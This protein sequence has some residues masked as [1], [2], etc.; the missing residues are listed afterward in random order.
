MAYAPVACRAVP[1]ERLN[2]KAARMNGRERRRAL[3]TDR[4]R[5]AWAILMVG[6]VLTTASV[7][8]VAGYDQGHDDRNVN[9]P[10]ILV[11]P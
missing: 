10:I 9:L 3:R 11:H 2:D 4:D 8:F 7:S 1:R 5:T 6:A